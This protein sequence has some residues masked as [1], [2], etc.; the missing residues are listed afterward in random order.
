[1]ALDNSEGFA[2]F[3]LHTALGHQ[4]RLAPVQMA[5]RTIAQALKRA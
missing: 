1:M 5:K 3:Y 4:Q 2:S